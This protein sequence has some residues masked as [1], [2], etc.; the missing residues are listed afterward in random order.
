MDL[1]YYLWADGH[2][3]CLQFA[4]KLILAAVH[5]NT[6]VEASLGYLSGDKLSGSFNR[7][8]FK[9]KRNAKLFS[10]ADVPACKDV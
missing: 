10:K 3:V 2:L 5:W 6:C 4:A 8:I 7:C 1:F 9:P